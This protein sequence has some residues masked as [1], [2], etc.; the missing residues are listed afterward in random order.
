[1]TATTCG[2]NASAIHEHASDCYVPRAAT[3]PVEKYG[4]GT[5]CER[6][7]CTWLLHLFAANPVEDEC[8]YDG[9]LCHVAEFCSAY[10]DARERLEAI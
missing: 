5:R 4:R 7:D 10:E 2:L 9:C 8:G 6:C 1:M 3:I